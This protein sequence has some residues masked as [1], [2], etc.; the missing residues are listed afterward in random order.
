[1]TRKELLHLPWY[2]AGHEDGGRWFVYAG[3]MG[4]CDDDRQIAECSTLHEA[5]TLIWLKNQTAPKD[6]YENEG[7]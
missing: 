1:M 6:F 4:N 3:E 2:V 7:I 5:N